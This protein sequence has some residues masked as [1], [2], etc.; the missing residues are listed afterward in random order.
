M[1]GSK[2]TEV[3]PPVL[4]PTHWLV[5]NT[6]GIFAYTSADQKPLSKPILN[7]LEPTQS[8]LNLSILL[9]FF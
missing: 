3:P 5:L 7:L 4:T 9:S 1:L 8:Y 2:I 6:N